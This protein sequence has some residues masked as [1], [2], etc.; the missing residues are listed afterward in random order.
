MGIIIHQPRYVGKVYDLEIEADHSF[1][2]GG[3]AVHNC[4]PLPIVRGTR[5]VE[6]VQRGPD[7]FAAQSPAFQRQAMG[8]G[9]FQAYRRGE[10]D[11]ADLSRAYTDGVYGE[12]LR[13]A[14]LKELGIR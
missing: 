5:W 10:V 11:V 1:F 2:A 8:P 12:M 14:T 9:M 13:A 7:W 3:I 6:S 4:S